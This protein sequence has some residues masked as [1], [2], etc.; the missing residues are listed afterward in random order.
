MNGCEETEPREVV[1]APAVGQCNIGNTHT[2][3]PT[4]LLYPIICLLTE[5]KLRV[6]DYYFRHSLWC[7][8][9]HH[10]TRGLEWLFAHYNTL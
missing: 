2:H 6:S 9:A 3:T 4:Q 1:I 8:L 5:E 7:Q 10:I